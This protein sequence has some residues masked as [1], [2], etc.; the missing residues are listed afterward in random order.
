MKKYFFFLVFA[1]GLACNGWAANFTVTSREDSGAGTLRDAI[2]QAN[3]NTEANTISFSL[4]SNSITVYS[5]INIT[6]PIFIDGGSTQV[7]GAIN[8]SFSSL[9][10][11]NGS[12][13]S[14]IQNISVVNSAVGIALYSNNNRV[15]GCRIGTNWADQAGIG[16]LWG[17]SVVG[18]NNIIGAINVSQRN[19]ISGNSGIDHVGI[20]LYSTG[21]IVVNNYIGVNSLGTAALPNGTGIYISNANRNLIGGNRLANEGN[22]ISGN[23]YNGIRFYGGSP[24]QGNTICG[25]I[26]GLNSAQT[27]AIPNQIGIGLE[28]YT[29]DSSSR[30]FI[31]LPQLGYENIIAGNN[32]TDIYTGYANPQVFIQNNWIGFNAVGDTFANEINGL[33]ITN[34]GSLVGGSGLHEGNFI[35]C[36]NAT[37]N[38]GVSGSG[39]T[40]VGNFIGIL[41]SG[42]VP[43]STTQYGILIG[44]GANHNIVGQKGGPGNL[45]TNVQTAIFIQDGTTTSNGLFSN[46]I[47]A[48]SG[49]GITFSGAVGSSA[50]TITLA[51]NNLVMGTG[52]AYD[53]IEIFRA[54]PRVGLAGGSLAF[55]GSTS[56]TAS[57]TWSLVPAGLVSGNYVCALATDAAGHNTSVFSSNVLV[58]IPT[59]TPT[60][61]VTQTATITPTPTISSTVTISPTITSTPTVSPTPLPY[62]PTPTVTPTV[63]P[64]SWSE[65]LRVACGPNPVRGSV[66]HLNIFTRQGADVEVKIF[67][68]SGREVN[69]FRYNY[70]SAGRHIE[71][72]FV[73]DLANGIYM[74]RVKTRNSD[75]SENLVIDKMALIKK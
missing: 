7:V 58:I 61:T 13:G 24:C 64:F 36:K 75:G 25:N 65:P 33:I 32:N 43:A 59:P 12:D 44:Y 8:T 17:I 42:L 63:T 40:L 74:V 60:G 50:P 9:V 38:V 41:P 16:N 27:A 56:V 57:G 10:F 30:N 54:E 20:G 1:V 4:G 23:T 69:T 11:Q 2:T 48:F 51:T 14:T 52:Q 15:Y 28:L 35:C 39:N 3:N 71:D 53:Y 5:T 72:I 21:S 45:I 37:N 70:S 34:F 31:G 55:V 62:T 18:A 66:A 73:G 46:T 29:T 22:L 6:R 47:C 19:I 49:N 68:P 26:I 67:T